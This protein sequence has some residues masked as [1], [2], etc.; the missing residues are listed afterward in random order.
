MFDEDMYVTPSPITENTN[1]LFGLRGQVSKAIE[2]VD[3]DVTISREGKQVDEV[4]FPRRTPREVA[5][6][7]LENVPFMVKHDYGVPGNFK[8][9][10]VAKGYF[11]D[12]PNQKH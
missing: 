6:W 1:L 8:I 11:K 5:S 10:F 12:D 9:R 2:E 3:M 7:Y 4:N